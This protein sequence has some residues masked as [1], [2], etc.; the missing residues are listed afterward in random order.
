MPKRRNNP[1]AL[2]PESK[3]SVCIPDDELGLY[4]DTRRARRE[5]SELRRKEI[6]DHLSICGP[7]LRKFNLARDALNPDHGGSPVHPFVRSVASAGQKTPIRPR[8]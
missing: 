8:G 1:A 6:N 7:C 2:A 3:P 5:I 4:A